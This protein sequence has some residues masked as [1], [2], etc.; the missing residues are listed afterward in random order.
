[1]NNQNSV[2]ISVESQKGG[3]GKTTVAL[4]VARMLLASGKY[5]VLF[6][7]LDIAGTDA[8]LTAE[9][10]LW[11]RWS[12]PVEF[13]MVKGKEGGNGIRLTRNLVELFDL[14]M[15]G[16]DIPAPY[17][18][19]SN[20]ADVGQGNEC[21]MS[22][23]ALELG[24]INIASSSLAV[25][26]HSTKGPMDGFTYGPAVLFDEAHSEW[27]LDMIR[28]FV[29]RA[30]R[31]PSKKPL[32]VVVDTSPGF[33]GLGPKV[34][35]WLTD[36]GPRNA[37]ILIVNSLDYQDLTA[38]VQATMRMSSIYEAKWSAAQAFQLLLNNTPNVSHL[39]NSEAERFFARLGSTHDDTDTLNGA[40]SCRDENQNL[41]FYRKPKKEEGD[42]YLADQ[43]KWWGIIF[44]RV[45]RQVLSGEYKYQ[46]KDF[47]KDCGKLGDGE[48]A[49]AQK[50]MKLFESHSVPYLDS[51][52]FQ[53]VAGKLKATP[54]TAK[55]TAYRREFQAPI[56]EAGFD[57]NHLLKKIRYS[58]PIAALAMEIVR[59]IGDLEGVFLRTISSTR[60]EDTDASGDFQVEWGR[61]APSWLF[62]DTLRSSPGNRTTLRRL[63]ATPLPERLERAKRF[64]HVPLKPLL[65]GIEAWI[66]ALPR[67]VFSSGLG[68]K[69]PVYV[70]ASIAAAMALRAS[71]SVKSVITKR[72]SH[73]YH[74][75]IQRLILMALLTEK[76]SYDNGFKHREPTLAYW[77]GLILD[78]RLIRRAESLMQ[79][80]F[81][82]CLEGQRIYTGQ[83]ANEF[84]TFCR[85][86]LALWAGVADLSLIR[87]AVLITTESLATGAMAA[88]VAKVLEE[89]L[90]QR[91]LSM[92]TAMTYLE[93]VSNRPNDKDPLTALLEMETMKEF[94]VALEPILGAD[95]WDLL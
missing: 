31:P 16:D 63:I 37:K 28:A 71:L 33:S 67:E 90:E 25:H 8:A 87:C 18:T 2:V 80:K 58:P 50:C 14:Y 45:P 56:H 34:E 79:G 88:L 47:I 7:D 38:C 10:T 35:E 95:K 61:V 53:F 27:F 21:N 43:E 51:F 22:H 82:R 36:I 89:A 92:E 19:E 54:A 85:S 23:A 86:Q 6:L 5:E 64:V 30:S 40:P 93:S 46:W 62:T 24:K 68:E 32:A 77:A 4:N 39:K 60:N 74:A 20:K 15:L 76:L 75:R 55:I 70:T 41:G 65:S 72:E 57:T 84:T 3:V 78:N 48:E 9:S 83:P 17:W 12:H 73:A 26:T 44:N 59:H 91:R 94:E 29:R 42:G 1:M 66:H 13:K 49:V 52:S 81:S 69:L 11:A